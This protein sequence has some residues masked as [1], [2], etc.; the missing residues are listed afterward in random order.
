M[1]LSEL[2][3]WSL[4][5]M[6]IFFHCGFN[7]V[8]LKTFYDSKNIPLVILGD[9]E[10]CSL[11]SWN[12][13][14]LKESHLLNLEKL[15]P[16]ELYS[17]IILAMENKPTYSESLFSNCN[18]DCIGVYIFPQ[19]IIKDTYFRAFQCKI[20]NNALYLNKK[21]FQF[22]KYLTPLCLY[23]NTFFVNAK[24]SMLFLL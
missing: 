22:G 21:L 1:V 20:L 6:A 12:H 16:K 9:S 3:S 24:L 8:V 2:P 15:N 7:L 17:I 23:C 11:I 14:L 18:F 19:L 5:M 4:S 10:G 13:H